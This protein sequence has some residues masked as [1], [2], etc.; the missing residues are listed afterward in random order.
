MD[1]WEK[2]Y[3]DELGMLGEISDGQWHQ[4]LH[5]C[6]CLLPLL[7]ATILTV[8]DE[9]PEARRSLFRDT[10]SRTDI[11]AFSEPRVSAPMGSGADATP[12][13][14][15]IPAPTKA[16]NSMSGSIAIPPVAPRLNPFEDIDERGLKS[17]HKFRCS[18]E[19][20]IFPV[21]SWNDIP[22]DSKNI[23]SQSC[24]VDPPEIKR[25]R[26]VSPPGSPVSEDEPA[27][28]VA[29][30]RPQRRRQRSGTVLDRQVPI[31]S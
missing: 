10:A 24:H 5:E 14:I 15:P 28:Q 11:A 17:L 31:P 9:A 16:S 23:N 21:D 12:M 3:E 27:E 8:T 26:T 7:A 4:L 13:E 22:V 20:I 25:A 18:Q 29:V 19:R 6:H 1:D 2:Q 30:V